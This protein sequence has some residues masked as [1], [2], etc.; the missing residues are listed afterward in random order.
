MVRVAELMSLGDTK[1]AGMMR[2]AE[3]V[4]LDGYYSGTQENRPS[5]KGNKHRVWSKYRTN[6]A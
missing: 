5:K 3:L 4:S 1:W 2:V 6:H